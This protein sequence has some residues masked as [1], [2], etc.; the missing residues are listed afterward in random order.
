MSR[1][2]AQVLRD[3]QIRLA[4]QARSEKKRK[5]YYGTRLARRSEK[6]RKSYYGTGLARRSKPFVTP[7]E[8]ACK[9]C[10]LLNRPH[11]RKCAACGIKRP[12]GGGVRSKSR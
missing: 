7:A 6:K 10:T 12:K 9:R 5:S 8:W 2:R 11:S 4:A 3:I 1:T